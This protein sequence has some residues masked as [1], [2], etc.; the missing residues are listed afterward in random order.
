MDRK[1]QV[2]TTFAF[3]LMCLIG[4][5]LG[6]KTLM[7]PTPNKPTISTTRSPQSQ[8]PIYRIGEK[9]N[10]GNIDFSKANRTL[11]LAV[12]KGCKFCEASMPFYKSLGED[13][14]ITAAARIIV[15]AP[16]SEDT[17]KAELLRNNVRVS[18][19]VSVPP[20][21]L[22]IRGTPTA[23]LVDHL[24]TVEQVFTGRLDDSKQAQLRRALVSGPE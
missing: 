6:I 8:T 7:I 5:T 20:G 19:V 4:I 1:L 13:A 12:R 18:Q 22:K 3:L 23:I 11:L 9:V 17:S 10:I 15:I 2:A 24:G 21:S 14:S 16:D